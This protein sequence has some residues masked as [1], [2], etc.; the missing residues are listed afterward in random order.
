M[1]VLLSTPYLGGAGG[2]ER[3]GFAAA[4][5]LVAAGDTVTLVYG[6]FAGGPWSEISAAVRQVPFSAVQRELSER[7]PTRW[8][9]RRLSFGSALRDVGAGFDVHLALG[10]APNLRGHIASRVGL[11]SPRGQRVPQK[12]AQRYDAVAMQ[13]PSNRSLLEAGTQAVLLPP[14]VSALPGPEA[15][16][17]PLPTDF[18]LTVFN[19]YGDVKGTDGVAQVAAALPF[20]LV[21]CH[22]GRTA[23]VDMPPE[24]RGHPR[25]VHVDDPTPSELRWMYERA[26]AYIAFSRSEGF[27]WSIADALHYSQ[28][29]VSRPVGILSF[30]DLQL[31]DGV[32]IYE[33]WAEASDVI[34]ELQPGRTPRVVDVVSP[35]GFSERLRRAAEDASSLREDPARGL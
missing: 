26:Q 8:L 31:L 4:N 17:V 6:R 10:K 32:G 7:R 23:P 11:I 24:L 35:E 33:D 3:Y 29:V 15:P 25:V 30:E 5:A 18:A 28:R 20:P 16:K 2:I 21:W 27:G 9:R 13:A 14:P 1:R 19:P 22:S 34:R 12:T